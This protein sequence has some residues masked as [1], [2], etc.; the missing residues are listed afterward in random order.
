MMR[1]PSPGLRIAVDY[2][3]LL[4]FFAANFLLPEA[5]A[6]RI[7]AASTGFAS[8]MD[9]MAA[10]VI[11]RVIVATGLFVVAT[12]LAMVV[13]RVKLGSISPMLWLSGGLVVVFGGL[14]V[15]FQNP[16]FIKMKPTIVYAMM[17]AVLLFGLITGRPLLQAVLGTAY[18]GL[19]ATGWRKLTRNWAVFFVVMALLNETVWRLTA[20]NP[21]DN[22]NMWVAYKLWG[23]IPL[24]MVFALANVPM[25]LKHGLT[26]G[27][28][29]EQHPPEA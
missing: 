3:P 7:V 19:D 20:P 14:T 2:A 15:Y 29:S 8:G 24:T 22:P 9:R 5:L 23:A 4:V 28:T 27:N 16:N 10:L 26:S 1:A 12:V 17:S 13:S 6:M 18:P 25:L 11:A 21:G